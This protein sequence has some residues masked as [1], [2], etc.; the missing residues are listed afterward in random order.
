MIEAFVGVLGTAFLGTVGWAFHMNS[1]VSVI[2]TKYDG[3][4]DLLNVH[5]VEVNRRLA[6][7]ERGMNGHLKDLED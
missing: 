5:F 1:R 7:I 3:L 6:R 2:E 4:E